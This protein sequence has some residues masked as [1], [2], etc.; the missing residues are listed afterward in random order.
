MKII[1]FSMLLLLTW[2]GFSGIDLVANPIDQ[3]D[4]YSEVYLD[5]K[6]GTLFELWQQV[7]DRSPYKIS[8]NDKSVKTIFVLPTG[9]VSIEDLIQLTKVELEKRDLKVKVNVEDYSIYFEIKS[10]EKKVK[11]LEV[12]IVD[13]KKNGLSNINPNTISEN[14]KIEDTNGKVE[15]FS[16]ENIK[17][18]YSSGL[19]TMKKVGKKGGVNVS[20][21][22][23]QVWVKSD[24]AN[25]VGA[26]QKGD[27]YSIK[28]GFSK[29]TYVLSMGLSFLYFDDRIP[30]SQNVQVGNSNTTY[31]KNSEIDGYSYFLSLGYRNYFRNNKVRLSYLLGV[32]ESKV[33]RR[34]PNCLNCAKQDLKLDAGF[35]L[36][37][38][39]VYY[40]NDHH[41]VEADYRYYISNADFVHALSLGYNYRF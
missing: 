28:F 41:G 33:S 32:E 22:Y 24:I 1:T 35:Y 3:K 16:L 38:N 37:P 15:I 39:F 6:D 23:G 25:R 27:K 40:F 30:F 12:K 2:G 14:Q 8:F 36:S 17:N 7:E 18:K 26:S 9:M 31:S 4:I 10:K 34:I 5:I 11:P 13:K 19:L 29:K 21:N 20:L